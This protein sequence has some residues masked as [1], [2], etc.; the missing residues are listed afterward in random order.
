M[1]ME[2]LDPR[3][4][5]ETIARNL[6]VGRTTV[7]SRLK[8]WRQVGF[9]L[10]YLVIPNPDL[11]G[12]ASAGQNLRIDDP[13][14]KP[15]V[16]ESLE[17]VD[18]VLVVFDHVGP[19][20]AVSY[21]VESE[22]ALARRVKLV[23]NLPGVSATEPAFSVRVPQATIVPT[24]LDW[25]IIAA[26]RATPMASLKAVADQVGISFRTLARRYQALIRAN[27]VWFHADLDYTRFGGVLTH[28]ILTLDPAASRDSILDGLRSRYPRLLENLVAYGAPSE[29]LARFL[30]VMVHFEAAGEEDE[31]TRFMLN[32]SGVQEVEAL[33]PTRTWVLRPW[34]DERIAERI[35]ATS[36][37][38]DRQNARAQ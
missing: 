20:I 21:A 22:S 25:R 19:W 10:G 30:E 36:R 18:G 15:R 16:L 33:H 2:G 12:A 26:L 28:F 23:E 38:R 37:P 31:A 13:R 1:S 34:F 7:Q 4:S 8:T 11:F 6:R 3:L 9:L 24:G 29:F 17:L 5:T 27:A 35:K 32:L 14:R